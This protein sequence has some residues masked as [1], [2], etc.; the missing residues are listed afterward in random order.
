LAYILMDRQRGET[1]KRYNFDKAEDEAN[2]M[3]GR[4]TRLNLNAALDGAEVVKSRMNKQEAGL[5]SNIYDLRN[6][7]LDEVR[8]RVSNGY[9]STLNIPYVYGTHN[10]EKPQKKR[11]LSDDEKKVLVNRIMCPGD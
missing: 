9:M 11:D 7:K 4:Y 10:V 1:D 3:V 8:G 2:A 5:A 6:F